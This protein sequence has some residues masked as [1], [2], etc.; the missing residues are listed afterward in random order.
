MAVGGG[1]VRR[2]HVDV[3]ACTGGAFPGL[4]SHQS[5]RAGRRRSLQVISREG[6]RGHG[7]A[8][9]SGGSSS[10]SSRD[11]VG[12]VFGEEGGQLLGVNVR[13]VGVVARAPGVVGD[14]A[15]RCGNG[16]EVTVAAAGVGFPALRHADEREVGVGPVA[17]DGEGRAALHVVVVDLH[18]R[19]LRREAPVA[20]TR[21][22]QGLSPTGEV[23]PL[24]V[25]RLAVGFAH[26]GGVPSDVRVQAAEPFVQVVLAGVAAAR[27]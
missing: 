10:S 9:A 8:F 3:S 26:L 4:D 20:A 17:T 24:A 22:E 14:V 2:P 18:R 27:V 15:V 7:E 6:G 16:S 5:G 12:V 19:R 11:S 13:A 25:N 1:V 23:L 21:V